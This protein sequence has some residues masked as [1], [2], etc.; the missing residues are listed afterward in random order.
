MSYVGE[1]MDGVTTKESLDW[2]DDNEWLQ[3]MD[4]ARVGWRVRRIET[5]VEDFK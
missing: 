2:G 4:I 1:M 3:N 5:N